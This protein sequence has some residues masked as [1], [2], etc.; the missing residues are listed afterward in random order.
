MAPD[1][2]RHGW[3]SRPAPV[4]GWVAIGDLN[5]DGKPD[6]AVTN[7][8]ANTVSII[9]G[10]GDGTFGAKTDLATGASPLGLAIADLDAD[11]HLD[12]A[13]AN[14]GSGTVSVRLGHGD[15]TFSAAP[16]LVV[17]SGPYSVAIG[18]LNGDGRPDIAAVNSDG[19]SVSV[20]LGNGDGTFTT[21][22][23][24]PLGATPTT[25][26]IADLN[27]DSKL[28]L[29]VSDPVERDLRPAQSRD[30]PT[31]T[32]LTLFEA[33]W[34]GEK[35]VVRWRFGPDAHVTGTSLERAETL[36]G[37]WS[38]SDAAPRLESRGNVV[39]DASVE[40]GRSY[41]YRLN[42]TLSGGGTMTFGPITANGPPSP[43][44]FALAPVAPSVG[45][46]PARI[47]FW[48]PR[49]AQVRLTVLD[50]LGRRVAEL[51]GGTLSAGRHGAVWSRAA[52]VPAG[53]YLVR[54]EWPGGSATRRLALTR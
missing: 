20:L 30:F 32:L 25:V 21:E 42:A 6:L 5:E 19:H 28:D 9:P 38:A 8:D 31:A 39:E 53:L 34:S 1:C 10:H 23:E 11:G 43:L 26:A 24:Y 41:F 47:T 37:P 54:Y 33:T 36:T 40:A 50:V 52:G 3:T 44:E 17:G 15:G 46:G 48:L 12:L 18:D 2:S 14:S 13:L 22:N 16:D 29:A 35:V 4:P 49:E 27:G 51:A 7:Y 45:S